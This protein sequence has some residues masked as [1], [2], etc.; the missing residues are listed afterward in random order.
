MPRAESEGECENGCCLSC[1]D[2]LIFS[3]KKARPFLALVL[4]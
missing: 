4:C 1:A 2:L 3:Q